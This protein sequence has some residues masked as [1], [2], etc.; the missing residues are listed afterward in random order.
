LLALPGES[1]AQTFDRLTRA[2]LNA[3]SKQV[4]EASA[5]RAR[6]SKIAARVKEKKA[7]VAKKFSFSLTGDID[8]LYDEA[9]KLLFNSALNKQQHLKRQLKKAR[10]C[11]R[12]AE[13]GSADE[14]EAIARLKLSIQDA[15]IFVTEHRL[16][17]EPAPRKDAVELPTAPVE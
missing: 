1:A 15:G 7:A 5:P 8:Q 14:R 16:P 12:A 11:A 3:G 6:N 4:T 13:D 9:E 10:A 17:T 2:A